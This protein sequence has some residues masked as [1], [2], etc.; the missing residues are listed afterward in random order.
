MVVNCGQANEARAEKEVME[1]FSTDIAVQ[2]T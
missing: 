1:R 2:V